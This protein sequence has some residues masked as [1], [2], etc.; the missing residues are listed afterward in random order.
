MDPFLKRCLDLARI[1]GAYVE[2]NPRVGAVVVHKGSI[3]GEGWHELYG[4]PHAEVNAVNSVKDKSLLPLSTLY[5]SLEPCNHHGKTPPCTQLILKSRIPKVVIGALDPNPKMA[6]SSVALLRS[7]GVEVVVN[8]S[9]APFWELNKHFQY[10][11]LTQLPFITLKWAESTDGFIAGLSNQEK[12]LQTTISPPFLSRWVHFLRHEHQA[13]MVGKHTVI[14]D[15]PA[16]TTR[17]WPGYSPLKIFFDRQL[18]IPLTAKIYNSGPVVVINELRN[19]VV[20]NATYFVPVEEE[21][22]LELKMLLTELYGRLGI[23]SILVEG[24]KNLLDQFIDQEI[25]NE[26]WRNVGDEQL[27]NGIKAP[28]GY[29]NMNW[30]PDAHGQLWH[31]KNPALRL[32]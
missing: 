6:G 26:I 28:A 30:V 24:G 12:P 2:P 18:E 16:L 1:P 17:K 14:T 31:K 23:G 21:A 11:Q 8:D 22:F 29:G 27:G 32:P 4:A 20:G 7:K 10:N 3:I 9:P 25:W 19:E 5:V 15:D 13:I